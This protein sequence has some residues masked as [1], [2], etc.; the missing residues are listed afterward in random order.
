MK[1]SLSKND[2]K[3]HLQCKRK[4]RVVSY[5]CGR[6]KIESLVRGARV[7]F[8]AR[9]LGIS[10]RATA[11][12][13]PLGCLD[14][15]RCIRGPG[16]VDRR[17]GGPGPCFQRSRHTPGALAG[18]DGVE[19]QSGGRGCDEGD[20][21]DD[22]LASSRVLAGGPFP[23]QGVLL[24]FDHCEDDVAGCGSGDSIDASERWL[25]R[26]SLEEMLG[27]CYAH[28]LLFEREV[29]IR[30]RGDW[31]YPPPV[32][33]SR[34][35]GRMLSSEA[36]GCEALLRAGAMLYGSLC[37]KQVGLVGGVDVGLGLF[38]SQPMAEGTF[39]GEYTGVLRRQRVRG[40]DSTYSFALPVVDPDLVVCAAQ[41]GN[42]CRLMN[43]SD[44]AW[45]AELIAVHHEGLPHVVCRLAREVAAGDQILINYGKKYWTVR[46]RDKVQLSAM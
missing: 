23:P 21:G 10:I 14:T 28:H 11:M 43:H 37:I 17:S 22:S 20:A 12:A 25:D 31:A 15:D 36:A 1:L 6:S 2:D 9:A 46:G 8:E 33:P 18:R 24:V 7:S 40:D 45:N 39:I 29:D 5:Q 32:S 4:S 38:A 16:A 42:L 27:C 13:T 35:F 3:R 44:D 41:Y 34:P 30:H 19:E 26:E